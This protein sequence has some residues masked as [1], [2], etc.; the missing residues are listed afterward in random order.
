L[1]LSTKAALSGFITLNGQGVFNA[2]ARVF[3]FTNP[4]TFSGTG[5]VLIIATSPSPN[6]ALFDGEGSFTI[7]SVV[8]NGIFAAFAGASMMYIQAI[9]RRG[10][11]GPTSNVV[12][13]GPGVG[14]NKTVAGPGEGSNPTVPGPGPTNNTVV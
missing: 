1:A 14:T 7:A 9:V 6:R 4:V 3:S 8:Y 10:P 2:D 5:S 13:A 11:Q 12:V